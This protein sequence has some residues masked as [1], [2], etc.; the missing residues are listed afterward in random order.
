MNVKIE[1]DHEV[2]QTLAQHLWVELKDLAT[3]SVSGP[4][5]K[6]FLQGQVTCDIEKITAENS[7]LGAYCN[8]KGRV[9]SIFHVINAGNQ[10]LLLLPK[11]CLQPIIERL[12]KIAVFSKVTL[13]SKPPFQFLYGLIGSPWDALLSDTIGKRKIF[14]VINKDN[15]LIIPLPSLSKRYLVLTNDPTALS[16]NF[17]TVHQGKQLDWLTQ[18]LLIGLPQIYPETMALFTPHML[19]LKQQGAVSFNKGCYV[20]QE[21]IARTEHLGKTKRAL[22]RVIIDDDTSLSSSPEAH[23][24]ENNHTEHIVNGV[25]LASNRKLA[26]VVRQI[27]TEEKQDGR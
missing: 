11:S 23:S 2:T 8:N 12:Q 21:I 25:T 20:G 13:S 17:K 10:Y 4:D 27:S 14:S 16:A 19:N 3:I 18:E 1:N 9:L 22:Y 15:T 6:S 5:A 24:S 26:L 7:G